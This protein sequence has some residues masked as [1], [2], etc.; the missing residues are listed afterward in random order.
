MST[1]YEIREARK[2]D[3]ERATELISRLK[4]LNAEFD[5]LLTP[6]ETLEEES[7]RYLE[8]LMADE[9]GLVLVVT[10]EGRVEGVLTARIVDRRFYD[11]RIVG[12]IIDV[13]VMPS[14]RRRGVGAQ[15]LE[16]ASRELKSKGADMIFAEFPAKNMIANGFYNK[17]GFRE[18]TAIFAKET[19]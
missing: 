18:I 2:E 8:E 11:P 12:Q 14:F 9:H 17:L 19:G 16:H 1:S 6:V 3:L 7:R 13:Y 4:Y 15:L 10:F 5:P